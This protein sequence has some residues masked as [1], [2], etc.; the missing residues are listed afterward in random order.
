[1]HQSRKTRKQSLFTR[2]AFGT[3]AVMAS[4]V[5]ALLVL[6]ALLVFAAACFIV[7]LVLWF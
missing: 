5:E 3:W 2:L 7:P 6:A 4:A 1:M